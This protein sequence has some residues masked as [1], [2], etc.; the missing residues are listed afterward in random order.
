MIEIVCL[1]TKRDYNL[2]YKLKIWINQTL[3]TD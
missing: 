1:H 2:A 3:Q